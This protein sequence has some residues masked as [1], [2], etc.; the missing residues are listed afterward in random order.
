MKVSFQN[1]EG[2]NLSAFLDLPENGEV[3]AYAIFAHCFTC[4][5]SLSA[6]R[7]ISKAITREGFGLLR[8]DF[9]GLGSSEGSFS[10]TNFSSNVDELLRAAQFLSDNYEP[11]QLLIGHSLGGAAVLSATAQLDSVRAVTTVGAPYGAAHVQHMFDH[12]LDEIESTGAAEVNIGGRPFLVKKQFIDDL[13]K[14]DPKVV[15]N[16]LNASLLVMHSPQDSVV[17]VMNATKIYQNAMHPKS[18][19]TLDGADHVLSDKKDSIYAGQVISAWASRYLDIESAPVEK[20]KQVAPVSV[21]LKGAGFTADVYT[22][23][24][25]LIADEPVS[26]GGKNLGPGPFDLLLS[27]LG[28]CTAMTLR[29]YADR[30][31]W[32]ITEIKTHLKAEREDGTFKIYKALEVVGDL[33]ETQRN[34][35]QEIADKCPVHKTLV[36]NIESLHWEDFE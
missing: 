4:S 24:H 32:P 34:R 3:K 26:V 12:R 25:H 8:F 28:A 6:V 17:E 30:K 19:I 27:S 16:S 18:F 20:R 36:G 33:D 5:K 10:D 31:K 2:Q 1:K 7:N 29:M 13:A 22:S 15:L 9:T 35:L 11:P 23:H 14:A 21:E